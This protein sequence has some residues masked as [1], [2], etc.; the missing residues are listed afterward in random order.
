M[1]DFFKK[2]QLVKC[3]YLLVSFLLCDGKLT[4]FVFVTKRDIQGRLIFGFGKTLINIFT[5]F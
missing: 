1:S 5:I 2:I 3:S 4:G